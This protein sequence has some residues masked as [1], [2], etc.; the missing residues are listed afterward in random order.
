MKHILSEHDSEKEEDVLDIKI[1]YKVL[2]KNKDISVAEIKDKPG[3][4]KA[5]RA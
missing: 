5:E 2:K 1:A 4:M 3:N